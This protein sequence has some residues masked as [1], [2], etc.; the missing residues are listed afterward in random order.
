[1]LLNYYRLNWK[2]PK[3]H[4]HHHSSHKK[5]RMKNKDL[6]LEYINMCPE[7]KQLLEARVS[8]TSAQ[9]AAPKAQPAANRNPPQQ[10]NRPRQRNLTYVTVS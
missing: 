4:Q 10:R 5:G 7:L 8:K 3:Q 1:M 2:K 9:T 6:F